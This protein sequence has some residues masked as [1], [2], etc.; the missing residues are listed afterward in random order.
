MATVAPVGARIAALTE[1]RATVQARAVAVAAATRL[2][3]LDMA[4][5]IETLL[6]GRDPTDG[7]G[8]WT[9]LGYASVGGPVPALPQAISAAPP[10]LTATEGMGGFRYASAG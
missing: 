6:L 3:R 2:G 5:S 4:W 10:A 8:D 1:T 9:L 7:D